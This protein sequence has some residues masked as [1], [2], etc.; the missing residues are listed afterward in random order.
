MPRQKPRMLHWEDVLIESLK[1]I[2]R[3]IVRCFSVS[4]KHDQTSKVI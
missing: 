1:L 4:D 2:I 3:L